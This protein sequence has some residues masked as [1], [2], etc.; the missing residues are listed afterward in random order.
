MDKQCPFCAEVIKAE[1]IICKHCGRELTADTPKTEKTAASKNE[2][3]NKAAYGL[4]PLI[5]IFGGCPLSLLFFGD[6]I[7]GGVLTLAGVIVLAYGLA[8]GEIKLFG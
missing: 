2:A 1:A 8:K 5:L 6:W 7:T 4:L 3:G